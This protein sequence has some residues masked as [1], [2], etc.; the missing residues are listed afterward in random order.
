M[1]TVQWHDRF[2]MV[3]SLAWGD[4]VHFSTGYSYS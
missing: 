2:I 1:S 3:Q 4:T